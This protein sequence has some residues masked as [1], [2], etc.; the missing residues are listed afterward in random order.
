MITL[1]LLLLI[2]AFIVFV[3][4]IFPLP[5]KFNLIAL[6]LALYVLAELVGRHV[7]GAG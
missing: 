4:A 5:S 6:G 3:I 2:A 1:S 7:I